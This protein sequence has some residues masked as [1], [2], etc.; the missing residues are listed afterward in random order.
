MNSTKKWLSYDFQSLSG[1]VMRTHN[2]FFSLLSVPQLCK[3]FWHQ[4]MYHFNTSCKISSMLCMRQERLQTTKHIYYAHTAVLI[5]PNE[6][7]TLRTVPTSQAVNTH[8]ETLTHTLT[9]QH[10]HIPFFLQQGIKRAIL[11][12]IYFQR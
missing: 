9:L 8:R 2:H 6:S 3:L 5:L 4:F 12:N 10:H 1:H 11:F 7:S